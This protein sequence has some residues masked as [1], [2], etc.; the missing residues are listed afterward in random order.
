M[1]LMLPIDGPLDDGKLK[2]GKELSWIHAQSSTPSKYCVRS[3]FTLAS[4]AAGY[5]KLNIFAL[6]I[7]ELD[8]VRQQDRQVLA[9]SVALCL[10]WHVC[11]HFLLRFSCA[12]LGSGFVDDDC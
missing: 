3:M 10:S 9:M 12:V 5:H 7:E 1:S 11:C 6:V 2:S 4:R 8:G